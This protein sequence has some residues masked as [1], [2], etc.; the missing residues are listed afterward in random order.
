LGTSSA[1]L[2]NK[3]VTDKPF[4]LSDECWNGTVTLLSNS[5]CGQSIVP[6][7]GTSR[8]VAGDDIT[9]DANK[10]DYSHP[11]VSQQGTIPWQTYQTNNGNVI[12]GG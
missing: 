6:V 10:C 4:Y 12:Y 9:T 1:S 11:G 5:L 3:I 2:A 7:Y 8:T